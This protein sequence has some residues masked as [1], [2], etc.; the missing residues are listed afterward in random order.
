[1]RTI[2]SIVIIISSFKAL[3]AIGGDSIVSSDT[4]PNEINYSQNI[5]K[6]NEYKVTTDSTL[7]QKV[8]KANS[9]E[10][11]HNFTSDYKKKQFYESP[12]DTSAPQIL[13]EDGYNVITETN[14]Q[15]DTIEE[16]SELTESQAFHE[17]EIEETGR[18]AIEEDS[19]YV[20]EATE[21]EIFESPETVPEKYETETTY[22]EIA[23][24]YEHKTTKAEPDDE[25]STM[26]ISPDNEITETN[27]NKVPSSN[28]TYKEEKA[29]ELTTEPQLAEKTPSSV[30]DIKGSSNSTSESTAH[31]IKYYIQIAASATPLSNYALKRLYLIGDEIRIIQ[32]E[33][34]FKYQIPVNGGYEMAHDLITTKNL[35]QAFVVPYQNGLKIN[36]EDA[37]KAI[38]DEE[39]GKMIW[40]SKLTELK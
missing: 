40:T 22:T 10:S 36:M 1:M 13:E 19:Y 6:Y 2:L 7:A 12:S 34:W 38:G 35:T 3:F 5:E 20:S 29:E 37:W 28:T 25:P 9:A 14:T 33:G 8:L 11:F 26:E 23:E 15:E 27:K 17:E 31:E 32:E 24:E 18:P 30:I 39:I 16:E 21:E 4:V